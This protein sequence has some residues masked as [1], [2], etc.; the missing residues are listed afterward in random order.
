MFWRRQG[1]NIFQDYLVDSLASSL[2]GPRL[3]D[4]IWL[5]AAARGPGPGGIRRNLLRHRPWPN[6]PPPAGAGSAPENSLFGFYGYGAGFSSGTG[7]GS[8]FLGRAVPRRALR[9]PRQ[10]VDESI[11]SGL[12]PV[13]A[14][15]TM[16][17]ATW[18]EGFPSR[19]HQPARHLQLRVRRPGPTTPCRGTAPCSRR[20]GD[21]QFSYLGADGLTEIRNAGRARIRSLRPTSLGR[22]LQ[23]NLHRLG[24]YDANSRELLRRSAGDQRAVTGARWAASSTT[25]RFPGRPTGARRFAVAGDRASGAT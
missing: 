22:D 15:R 4:T 16:I 12:Q 7:E 23:P 14:D 17:Y 10:Q 6:R 3:A 18:S 9:E 19:R 5:T 2:R 25:S 8:V 24:V 13:L 20:T 21:F 1:H 11:R